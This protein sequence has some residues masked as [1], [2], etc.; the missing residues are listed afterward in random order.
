VGNDSAVGMIAQIPLFV[1]NNQKATIAQADTQHRTAE[2][3]LRQT[4]M[5]AL[6]DLA[7]AYQAYISARNL[8]ALYSS[9]N[10]VQVENLR[11]TAEYS[12]KHGDSSLF[13]YLDVAR[14]ARQAAVSANQA[15]AGYQ[16]ALWQME[17]AV[18]TGIDA[19][20][21]APPPSSPT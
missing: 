15:R 21:V 5:Q 12:Y 9:E 20:T 17:S 11:A 14:T 1:Y 2:A 16:L 8:L 19:V 10:L 3:Q 6:T 7:K 13:E 18:A 4:E